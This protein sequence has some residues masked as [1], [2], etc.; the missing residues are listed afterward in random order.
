MS[1]HKQYKRKLSTLSLGILCTFSVINTPQLIAD[2]AQF[3]QFVQTNHFSEAQLLYSHT[4]MFNFDIEGYLK[5]NAP[6]LIDYAETISH[7]SGY[8]SISPKV[9][10]AL[11]ETQTRI[12]SQKTLSSEQLNNPMGILSQEENFSNQVKD[13]A[14][15][16]AKIHYQHIETLHQQ[17][18]EGI[19]T[20]SNEDHPQPFSTIET[21]FDQSQQSIKFGSIWI[22]RG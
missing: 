19:A 9:L 16:L 6:H 14:I 21:L 11:M 22:P 13:V 18:K 1:S 15:K 20:Y 3:A 10:I 17:K 4:E 7:W 8:S 2:E 5:Q 12:I